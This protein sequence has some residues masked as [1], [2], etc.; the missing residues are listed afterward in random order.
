MEAEHV[1]LPRTQLPVTPQ[2]AA[3]AELAEQL[4]QQLGLQPASPAQAAELSRRAIGLLRSAVAELQHSLHAQQHSAAQLQ[5]SATRHP[6]SDSTDAVTA[7][8]QLLGA[9]DGE[10]LLRSAWRQLRSHQLAIQ[11]AG[12]RLCDQLPMILAPAQLIGSARLRTD[13]AAGEPCSSNTS[14]Q[15]RCNSVASTPSK[16]RTRNSTS[17]SAASTITLSDKPMHRLLLALTACLLSACSLLS[18]YS[19]M[20]KIDLQSAP[21]TRLTRLARPPLARRA[22]AGRTAPPGGL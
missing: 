2:P 16:R 3:D 18:P 8:Q 10:E 5:A 7:M 12:N 6:L 13:G 19:D 22:A 14:K 21:P 17:C 9:A 1:R 4:C 20:T 15:G 11:Q